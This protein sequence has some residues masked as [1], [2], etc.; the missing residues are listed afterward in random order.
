M[1]KTKAE[2]Q[3][4]FRKREREGKARRRELLD[5]V[6]PHVRERLAQDMKW[7]FEPTDCGTHMIHW[8]MSEASRTFLTG[9]AQAKNMT[10]YDLLGEINQAILER[11]LRAERAR[12]RRN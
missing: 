7:V 3:R 6:S 10:V 1:A 8:D 5:D 12:S 4:L 9:Y 11:A 2:H